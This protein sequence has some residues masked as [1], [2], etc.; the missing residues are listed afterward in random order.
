VPRAPRLTGCEHH[1]F[2]FDIFW[3]PTAARE[4]PCLIVSFSVVFRFLY[5]SAFCCVSVRELCALTDQ[6]CVATTARSKLPITAAGAPPLGG[7]TL[8]VRQDLS[9]VIFFVIVSLQL[10]RAGQHAISLS[11]RVPCCGGALRVTHM[12]HGVSGLGRSDSDKGYPFPWPYSF[13]QLANSRR[14][15]SET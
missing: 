12:T 1:L 4:D 3:R 8:C 15:G 11:P 7:L 2:F 6:L 13:F 10:S 14:N 5:F 9:R